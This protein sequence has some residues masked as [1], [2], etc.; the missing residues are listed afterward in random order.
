MAAR[1]ASERN[2]LLLIASLLAWLATALAA[3]RAVALDQAALTGP[4][5]EDA[6]LASVWFVDDKQGWAVGDHGVIWHTD[7]AGGHWQQQ[8]SGIVCPLECVRFI[9]AQNGWIAGR[10]IHPYTHVST[11]V[12]LR[13]RDGGRTWQ[14]DPKLLLPGLKQIRFFSATQGVAWGDATSLLAA[15]LLTTDDGGRSWT[16][17]VA[18]ELTCWRAGDFIDPQ[19]GALASRMG[20]PLAVRGSAFVTAQAPDFRPRGANAMRL[21]AGS[22]SWLVG[23]G[24]LV[25]VS[26]DQGRRWLKPS[27]DPTATTTGPDFDWQAVAVR[28]TKCWIAGTPGT[29]VLHS[30]DA[31]HT[32]QTFTTGQRLP[33]RDLAFVDDDHGWAVGDFGLVLMTSDGGHSW[34]RQRSKSERAALVACYADPQSVPC[35][36]LARMAANEG[37]TAAVRLLTRCDLTS[38]DARRASLADR[39]QAGFGAIGAGSVTT[40]WSF[41]TA[42]PGLGLPTE[43][44]V[45]EWDRACQAPGAERIEAYLVREFRTLRPEVIVTHGVDPEGSDPLGHMLSQL[46]LRA[47]E[48][49]A[50]PGRFPEQFAQLGLDP[51]R[52]RKVFG[53]THTGQASG[54]GLTASQLAPRLGSTLGEVADLGRALI[55]ERPQPTASTIGFQ[56]LVDHVPQGA[57]TH[58]FFSGVTLFPG[59]DGRRVLIDSGQVVGD[60][61][62]R[63]RRKQRSL[64]AVLGHLDKN[65]VESQQMLAQIGE[66]TAD[67]DPTTA[68]SL[69]FQL[70][71]HYRR[72][73]RWAQALETFELVASR[74]PDHPLAEAAS[75]WLLHCRASR[76]VSRHIARKL[77][78]AVPVANQP[79]GVL[80]QVGPAKQV[81]SRGQAQPMMVA[82]PADFQWALAMARQIEQRFPAAFCEPAVQLSL[83]A[84]Q[85][86]AGLGPQ[87]TKA[88]QLLE[89]TRPHDA[90]WQAAASETWLDAPHGQSPTSVARA[91]LATTRPRLDGRLDDELWKKAMPLQLATTPRD[92]SL[93]PATVMLAYDAQFL[94]VAIRCRRAAGCA[95]ETNDAPRTRDA[96]LQERDRVELLLDLDRDRS[97]AYRLVVDHRGWAADD[98]WGDAS[99]NPNWFIAA[100]TADGAWTVEAA[101]PLAEMVDA[102]PT[103]QDAWALGVQRIVPGVGFQSWT[104]PAGTDICPEG[105]GLLMFD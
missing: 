59:S 56:L 96:D 29:R 65:G 64:H 104:T 20:G 84:A 54:A 38:S 52:V 13:T 3:P 73:G 101:I 33:I 46:V 71:E 105:F 9:D 55:V 14:R 4:L 15:G 24:G 49:S 72:Q 88:C 89:H 100:D 8:D 16:P 74:Y 86:A 97:T 95:Y 43:R 36:L 92:N 67:L 66:L 53:L 93:P 19:S 27:N 60:L 41:P 75:V 23:D 10:Q 45:N 103:N 2:R 44:I 37:Y 83:A 5:R 31:G 48:S 102:P 34:Q 61:M 50:D 47:A 51:W 82:Q 58:D 98:C 68:G 30:P 12:L 99:W 87:A 81:A 70:G 28:G 11:G 22:P 21:A 85:R 7:D 25:L 78:T 1:H 40:A 18:D 79:T 39:A 94:Y 32:W 6:A 90:W 69:I 80:A 42:E 91:S 26:E 17:L 57:G 76:E 35:E 63:T 62:Q 77:G